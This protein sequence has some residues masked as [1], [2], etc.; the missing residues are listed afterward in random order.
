ML[1]EYRTPEIEVVTI[2]DIISASGD[3][4]LDGGSNGIIDGGILG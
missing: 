4:I 3:N 1:K 2:S